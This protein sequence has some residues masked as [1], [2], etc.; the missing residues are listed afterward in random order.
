LDKRISKDNVDEVISNY[1]ANQTHL[2]EYIL[3]AGI[4]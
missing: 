2:A 4:K 3:G 1:G